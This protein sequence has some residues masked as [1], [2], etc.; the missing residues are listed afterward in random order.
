MKKKTSESNKSKS[1]GLKG[2]ALKQKLQPV[3]ENTVRLVHGAEALVWLSLKTHLDPEM[4]CKIYRVLCRSIFTVN[5]PGWPRRKTLPTEKMLK[6]A[7]KKVLK[8]YN[9][10]QKCG[11]RSAIVHAFTLA[12]GEEDLFFDWETAKER[13]K[14]AAYDRKKKVDKWEDCL[15]MAHGDSQGEVEIAVCGHKPMTQ[16]ALTALICHEGLHNMARRTRPGQ[17]YLSAEIEHIAMAFMGDP[18]L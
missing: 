4:I 14:G 18:Q 6:L 5:I 12:S 9:R 15:A 13:V 10:E 16:Q 8:F 1:L 2:R 17:K 11:Q 7:K 3:P